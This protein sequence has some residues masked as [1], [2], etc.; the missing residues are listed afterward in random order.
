L[1]RKRVLR[2]AEAIKREIGV[3]LDRRMRDPRL[4]MITVTRVELSDDLRHAKVFV[5]FLGGAEEKKAGMRL[6]TKARG[7]VRGELGSSLRLK[8][9]PELKFVLDDSS[10]NYLKIAEV[11]RRIH[12]DSNGRPEGSQGNPEDA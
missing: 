1:A 10:E 12:D 5:S 6:L 2:V 7:F 8:I 3:I 11:L 9:S 4:G